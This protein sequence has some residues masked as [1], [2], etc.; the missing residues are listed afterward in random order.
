MQSGPRRIITAFAILLA[1]VATGGLGYHLLG[2]GAWSLADSVYFALITVSTVGYQEMRLVDTIRGARLLTGLLI[3]IGSASLVFFQSSITATLVEGSLGLVY[4]RNRMR[5][6]IRALRGHVV[7]AGAGSTG[8]HA[9][10]ELHAIQ[11]PFVV[12]D[13][14]ID[15]LERISQELTGGKMLY[16]HGDATEDSVL[17][18]AGVQHAGSVVAALSA[19]RENLYVTLSA[20]SL[21]PTARIIAKVV[22]AEAT[23]K[24]VIAGA[25]STVSP[26][27]IGGQR[28]ASEVVRPEVLLFLD[29]MMRDKDKNLRLEEV[30]IPN[31][32]VYLGKALRNVPFRTQTNVL[33]VAARDCKGT[34]LY[35]PGPDFVLEQ[36]SVLIVLGEVQGMHKLNALLDGSVTKS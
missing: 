31:D 18:E 10:E 16:V 5:S 22:E 3:V 11:K 30:A 14:N 17:L 6:Q 35:N 34:F 9:I 21:N 8:K 12:I 27:I 33:V 20:R 23:R 19:D 13:S 26:N 25:N 36:G 1:V 4:R 28:M 29:Q 7:V 24:M 2:H 15:Q 32:S